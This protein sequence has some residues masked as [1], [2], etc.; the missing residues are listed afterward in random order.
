MAFKSVTVGSK[1][2]ALLDKKFQKL[3]QIDI[4]KALMQSAALV[5]AEAK[6]ILLREGHSKTGYL[7]QSIKYSEPHDNQIEVYTNVYY[8][9][10][11]EFG[12]GIYSLNKTG[13]TG[14]WV[15]VDE[16][17]GAPKSTER[18]NYT[19]EEACRVWHIL[20]SKYGEDKV[21]MTQGQAPVRFMKRALDNNEENIKK[22][23]NKFLGEEVKK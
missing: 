1:D 9:P 8:A 19:Y 13:R 10:Y 14:W 7:A 23:F 12:T 3:S 2:I 11:V 20:A 18:K 22:V 6:D 16:S 17:E 5:E 15:Y 4:D 21:H